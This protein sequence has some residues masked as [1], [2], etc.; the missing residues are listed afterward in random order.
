[1][2]E[3]ARSLFALDLNLRHG[4]FAFGYDADGNGLTDGLESLLFYVFQIFFIIGTSPDEIAWAGIFAAFAIN[5]VGL[6]SPD[7]GC[8][9]DQGEAKQVVH[10]FSLKSN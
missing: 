8:S 7:R 5:P 6:A 3:S 10:G 4:A 9:K 2:G 1:L